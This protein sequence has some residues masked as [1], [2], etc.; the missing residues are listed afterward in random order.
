M[1]VSPLKSTG[2]A[3]VFGGAILL[4]VIISMGG[5]TKMEQ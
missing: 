2:A 4:P 3:I 5:Q 1:P